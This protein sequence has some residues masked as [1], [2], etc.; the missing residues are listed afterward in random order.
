MAPLLCCRPPYLLCL[1]TGRRDRDGLE[2]EDTEMRAAQTGCATR[3][4][5]R[6]G[7]GASATARGR[8]HDGAAQGTGKGAMTGSPGTATATTTKMMTD[9][10]VVATPGAASRVVQAVDTTAR[11]P[12]VATCGSA[13]GRR[14]AARQAVATAAA[15]ASS[16]PRHQ[17]PRRP[18]LLVC[19]PSSSG[20]CRPS[21]RSRCSPTT[22]SR[23]SWRS[24]CVL[25]WGRLATPCRSSSTSPRQRS[26]HVAR[27]RSRHR[28]SRSRAG[29]GLRG[30]GHR[31]QGSP[32]TLLGSPRRLP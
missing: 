21:C 8:R 4:A 5:A 15:T 2:A 19:L 25:A 27:H 23:L 29:I 30:S 11:H 13:S 28:L 18:R 20:R 6:A 26:L 17:R 12:R 9:D 14:D 10:G 22:R 1:G 3:R 32:S 24:L 16:R 31:H 7:M